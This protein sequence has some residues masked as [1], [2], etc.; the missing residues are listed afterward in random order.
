MLDS[1]IDYTL[2]TASLILAPVLY[3]WLSLFYEESQI[4]KLYN[5]KENQ[6][7]IYISFAF[8]VIPFTFLTDV[9]IHNT[10]ELVHGWKIYDYISYQRYRFT[11]TFFYTLH[12]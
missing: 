5:I 11:V 4:A 8:F 6:T 10:L 7:I 12:I 9:F 2:D 3:Q 1:Y